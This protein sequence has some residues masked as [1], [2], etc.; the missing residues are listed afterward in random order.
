MRV[1]AR[2]GRADALAVRSGRRVGILHRVQVV[3]PAKRH[4]H[5]DLV[6]LERNQWQ[7]QARVRTEPKRER[8]VQRLS[9]NRGCAQVRIEHVKISA[10][11]REFRVRGKGW[12][13]RRRRVHAQPPRPVRR[14]VERRRVANEFVVRLQVDRIGRKELVPQVH[15]ISP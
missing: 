10:V 6:R 13:E 14:V 2:V 12:I 8:N 4:R 5:L 15:P 9:T 7:G 3:E 11:R 1:A